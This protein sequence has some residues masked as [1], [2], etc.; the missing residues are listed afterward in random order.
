MRTLFFTILLATAS[1]AFANDINVTLAVSDSNG[2]L[3][4]V[5]L[6]VD[7]EQSDLSTPSLFLPHVIFPNGEA[8]LIS[9][10]SDL[11]AVICE[12]L[13][14]AP[15]FNPYRDLRISYSE[16]LS[17]RRGVFSGTYSVRGTKTDGYYEKE[18]SGS[19]NTIR[20][21]SCTTY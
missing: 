20:L 12:K 7:W 10:D 13:T 17:F 9:A 8:A 18:I 1:F 21:L 16:L 3:Q 14:G 4:T 5:V 15:V 19:D 11:D 2:N 6:A